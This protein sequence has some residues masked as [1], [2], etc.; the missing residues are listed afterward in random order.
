MQYYFS[1]KKFVQRGFARYAVTTPPHLCVVWG[2]TLYTYII[3]NITTYVFCSNWEANRSMKCLWSLKKR[4]RCDRVPQTSSSSSS[5][6]WHKQT[7]ETNWEDVHNLEQR[8]GGGKNVRI[9]CGRSETAW[10]NLLQGIRNWWKHQQICLIL[11]LD[12]GMGRF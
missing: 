4:T 5:S 3:H 10:M 11:T 1:H 9:T 12:A 2:S 8:K 6:S 7:T